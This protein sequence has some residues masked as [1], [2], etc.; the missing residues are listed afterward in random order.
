MGPTDAIGGLF[1]LF[2]IGLLA[3]TIPT[4]EARMIVIT[5]KPII[6]AQRFRRV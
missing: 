6:A 1:S 2:D 3:D 5:P 4:E